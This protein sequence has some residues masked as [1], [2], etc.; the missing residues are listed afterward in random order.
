MGLMQKAVA[1]HAAGQLAEAERLYRRMLAGQPDH[2]QALSN[3]AAALLGLGRAA[4]ALRCAE[5]ALAVQPGYASALGNQGNA[6]L[7]LG[8]DAEALAAY[9]D[10]LTLDR[11]AAPVWNSRGN[12]LRALGGLAAAEDSYSVSLLLRPG[13]TAVLVNRSRVR[14]QRGDAAAALL[15]VEAAVV[16]GATAETELHRAAVLLALG[17]LE[18]AAA[19]CDGMLA[20]WPGLPAAL[21]VKGDALLLG[22]QAAAALDCYDAA[23]AVLPGDVAA[24]TNRAAALQRLRRSA[25]AL[26]ACDAILAR[27]PGNPDANCTRGSV[28]TEQGR[29]AEALAVFDSVLSQHPGHP[30]AACNRGHAL[31]ALGRF[32]EALDSYDRALEA[33]PGIAGLIGRGNV[34]L[35]LR[36]TPAALES[37]DAALALR[38]DDVAALTSRSHALR[39]LRRPQEALAS[40]DR[41]L[42]IDP[43][44]GAALLNRGVALRDLRRP[45]EALASLEAALPLLPNA[46]MAHSNLAA[47]LLSCGRPLD[48][49]KVC[50]EALA[51]DDGL[52]WAHCNKGI[53]YADLNRTVEALDS[54]AAAQLRDPALPEAQFGEAVTRL[55]AG[56]FVRGW[57]KYEWRWRTNGVGPLPC[58][59]KLWRGEDLTGQIILLRAEQ[60]FGDTLQFLRFVPMVLARAASV[61]LEVHGAVRGLVRDA[62][63]LQVISVGD[64]VPPHDWVCPL[65]SLPL[66]LGTEL[67]SIPHQVPYLRGPPRAVREAGLRRVGVVWSGSVGHVNDHNRSIALRCFAGVLGVAG[68][69]FVSLQPDVRDSDLAALADAPGLHQDR[70]ALGSF[71]ATAAVL[72]TLDLVITVD[73]AVAH[74][75][76]G[77]GHPVWVLLPFAPDW[78]WLLGRDDSPWYPTA[79]LFRQPVPGDWDAV[80]QDVVTALGS[81]NP[82]AMSVR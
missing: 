25:E 77:L 28:L 33:G 44:C 82:G 48:A 15:D 22:D 67:G 74:L 4:E 68:C 9:D 18:E 70:G 62:P 13:V 17:R 36:R 71:A 38:A 52:A 53:A 76:G 75:A 2:A 8:R 72:A 60:G 45:Q 12:A 64:P 31:R 6:L 66:A 32:A 51:L 20:T 81:V 11:M 50:D 49:L 21:T 46:A 7:A 78:R 41:A 80:V 30:A 63:G 59:Q 58:G 54:Y 73:S 39:D 56:D 42:A 37:L 10:L 57:P 14:L 47:A 35:E 1:C 24:Q 27:Q 61:V 79:R 69:E 19:A 26:D 65:L 55:L 5:R 43:G 29:P 16:G 23:L 34:L 3:R 40:A